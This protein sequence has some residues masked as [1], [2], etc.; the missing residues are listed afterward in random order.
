MSD[1]TKGGEPPV[2]S[3]QAPTGMVNV[4]R[5]V[6][7]AK[8]GPDIPVG[9]PTKLVLK[10]IDGENTVFTMPH[11]PLSLGMQLS[12]S[13]PV[14][15]LKAVDSRNEQRFASFVTENCRFVYGNSEPVVGPPPTR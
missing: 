8:V 10:T 15:K 2:L 5:D 7:Y 4:A 12:E 13:V 6:E 1:Q 3:P 9:G 14:W 11:D